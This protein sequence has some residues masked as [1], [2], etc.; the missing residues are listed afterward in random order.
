MGSNSM[1]G[2]VCSWQ[3]NGPRQSGF[4]N[5]PA[6]QMRERHFF[7]NVGVNN[8]FSVPTYYCDECSEVFDKEPPAGEKAW[9]EWDANP[10]KRS[11]PLTD[12]YLGTKKPKPQTRDNT[13][14]Y[15]TLGSLSAAVAVKAKGRQHLRQRMCRCR[16]ATT[17]L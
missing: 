3:R 4:C 12:P 2:R 13:D 11:E 7:A 15:N 6:T 9:R 8:F 17:S 16:P 1:E 10:N 5:R 14:P